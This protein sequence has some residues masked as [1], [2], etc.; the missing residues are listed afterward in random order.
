MKYSFG[1]TMVR[2]KV[3]FEID[4]RLEISVVDVAGFMSEVIGPNRPMHALRQVILFR[5]GM[6]AFC[7]RSIAGPIN[8][9][10]KQDFTS[11]RL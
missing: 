8:S 9:P 5:V 6:D 2:D 10:M 3:G 1:L 11:I 7:S 4:S